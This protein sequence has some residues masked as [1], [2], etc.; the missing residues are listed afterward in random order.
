MP[1]DTQYIISLEKKYL[2]PYIKLLPYLV[3]S[4][5]LFQQSEKLTNFPNNKI[6]TKSSRNKSLR[7]QKKKFTDYKISQL[8]LF[9]VFISKLG[10]FKSGQFL[11]LFSRTRRSK[12]GIF[13]DY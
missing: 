11:D 7:I 12:S 3:C 1:D 10:Q 13:I 6:S 9:H 4:K 8:K 5:L 2:S